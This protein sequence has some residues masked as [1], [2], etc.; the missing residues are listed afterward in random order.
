MRDLL[1]TYFDPKLLSLLNVLRH[2]SFNNFNN[3]IILIVIANIPP[4]NE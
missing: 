3:Y 1:T 2:C 4:Y